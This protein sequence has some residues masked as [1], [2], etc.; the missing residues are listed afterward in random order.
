MNGRAGAGTQVEGIGAA[1]AAKCEVDDVA[2]GT[3]LVLL[4]SVI[5]T[6]CHRL[7]NC[8]PSNSGNHELGRN[9]ISPSIW[10]R[11]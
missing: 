9:G 10:A 3:N 11:A 1:V 8:S 7:D 2:R 6:E 4:I 5:R